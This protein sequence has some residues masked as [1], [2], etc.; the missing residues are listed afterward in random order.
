LAANIQGVSKA[1]TISQEQQLKLPDYYEKKL[2]SISY[3]CDLCGSEVAR[4]AFCK[5]HP[6]ASIHRVKHHALHSICLLWQ[7]SAAG[8]IRWKASAKHAIEA[9]NAP[10]GAKELLLAF[11]IQ[12][13]QNLTIEES[14]EFL[15]WAA[16]LNGWGDGEEPIGAYQRNDVCHHCGAEDLTKFGETRDLTE[17]DWKDLALE[18]AVTCEWVTTRGFIKDK[19]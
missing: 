7:E 5:E 10:Q 3:H 19:N 18:H 11:E 4:N 8:A 16:S 17:A 1:C 9:K 15:D 6:R 2:M 14:N 12:G 13:Y